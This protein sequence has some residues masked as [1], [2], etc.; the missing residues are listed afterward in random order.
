MQIVKYFPHAVVLV[1][2]ALAGVFQSPSFAYA[3]VLALM[4]LLCGEAL[5]LYRSIHEK[6][7]SPID[8]ILKRKLQDVEARIAT[9]EYGTTAEECWEFV[10]INEMEEQNESQNY[11]NTAGF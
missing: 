6:K 11:F 3:S 7:N 10:L 2:L 9:V 5:E 1:L 4:V 8:D